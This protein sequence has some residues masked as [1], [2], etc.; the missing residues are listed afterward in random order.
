MFVFHKLFTFVQREN[1]EKLKKDLY[2][3]YYMLRFCPAKEEL[4]NKVNLLIKNKEQGKSVKQNIRK[5]FSKVDSQ[6]PILVE[7]ENG[8]DEYIHDLRQDIFERFNK[9]RKILEIKK[10]A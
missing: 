9:L 3:V 8:P 2:Y 1:K 10:N 5:Y 6:G 7:Q 4:I